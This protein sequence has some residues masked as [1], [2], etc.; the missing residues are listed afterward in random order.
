MRALPATATEDADWDALLESTGA[1]HVLQSK[2]WAAVKASGGWRA[3]RFVLRDDDGVAGAAQV[4][5][6]DLAAGLRYAYAP[7]GPLLRDLPR[8]GE[9]AAALAASLRGSGAVALLLDPEIPRALSGTLAGAGAV[10]APPV[11]PRRTLVVDLAPDPARLLAQMRRKTRQYIRKA[12]RDGVLTEE[13]DDIAAFYAIEEEVARRS[14]FGIH[15]PAYY[16]AIWTTLGRRG[17]AHLFFARVG[18]TRVATLLVLRFAGHAWEMF[19]GST[20]AFAE[21]RPFYLL[22]WRAMLRL[23][24]LGVRSYDMWGLADTARGDDPLAGVEHFKL[25][26]GGEQ[27]EYVGAWELPLRR[28]LFPLWRL[29]A[30]LLPVAG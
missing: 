18:A 14:A 7:R 9:A 6:R 5:L 27:R 12:E 8:I 28:A 24:Q 20:G 10:P 2:E 13:S 25:G 19:G 1:P 11:Q 29:A 23:R 26:F 16:E 22:K 4:L 3:R 30:R 21:R 17:R 15:E